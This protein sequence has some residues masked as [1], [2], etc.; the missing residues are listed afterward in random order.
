MAQQPITGEPQPCGSWPSPI[1][2]ELVASGGAKIDGVGAVGDDIWWLEVRPAEQGRAVLVSSARG[3]RLPAPWSARSRVHEYGGGSWWTGRRHVYL[4]DAGDQAVH[5]LLIDGSTDGTDKPQRVTVPAPA[6]Q[7]WRFAD[8]REHPD[9]SMI[10]CVR[11]THF[12]P[13]SSDEE[14]DGEE[15]DVGEPDGNP[16]REPINEIVVVPTHGVGGPAPAD[17]AGGAVPTVVVSG[18]DFVSEP[19]ISPNGQFLSW[20]Q[21]NHPNMP[22]NETALLVAPLVVDNE[23]GHDEESGSDCP[24]VSL[25]PATVVAS[26]AAVCGADWTSDGSLVY[27]SDAE[28]YWNLHRWSAETGSR[29][30]TS[31]SDAEIGAAPW[32]FGSRRWAELA[33][34]RLVVVVTGDAVDSLAVVEA[35]GNLVPIAGSGSTTELTPDAV[36]AIGT[37]VAVGDQA[38]TSVAVVVS[39]PATLPEIRMVDVD[40]RA[41]TTVRP[42]PPVGVGVDWLSVPESLWFESAGRPTHAFFYPPPTSV[43]GGDPGELPPLIVIGHGGPTSHNGP[44]LSLKIQYWTSRGFAVVDVNYGGSTGFGKE[45]RDRLKLAWGV[46]DVEDCINAA[47]HLAES[48]RVDG[49]RLAIR[50][51]S[52]GGLTVLSALIRSDRFAAGVSLYGVADLKALATDTHKFE[53]R[54]LDWLIG[55]YPNDADRYDQLSPLH[56]ISGITTPMLLMQGTDDKVVPPSQSEAVVDALAANKVDHAYVTFDGESHGFRRAESLVTSMELELWFYGQVF[57]FTPADHVV[58]PAHTVGRGFGLETPGS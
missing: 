6:G 19:R 17:G 29:P 38:P 54:Y 40:S 7:E 20:I 34:G 36:V 15:P 56:H 11:E 21:W 22:W 47:L 58:P 2:A 33:D 16:G 51:S 26:G 48:G 37:P 57:G 9:G 4:V 52:S 45:Y 5:R 46:V 31:L 43:G 41:I 13:D 3:D 14:S 24:P 18:L 55:R 35:D 32:V 30:L 50:G 39:T 44:E 49:K 53:S 12:H 8:G 28:G 42:S 23:G 25:G 10:V 1:S 27:S